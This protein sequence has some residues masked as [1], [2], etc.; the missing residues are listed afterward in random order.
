M[1]RR[2]CL[3]I[4]AIGL[5]LLLTGCA[6]DAPLPP[7]TEPLSL[8]LVHADPAL[9]DG[10]FRRLLDFELPSDLVFVR[11]EG[12][13]P[14]LSPQSPHSGAASLTIPSGCRS[15]AVNLASLLPAN[16]PLSGKWALAGAYL[17]CERDAQVTVEYTPGGIQ[18]SQSVTLTSRPFS[19]PAGQWTGVFVDLTQQPAAAQRPPGTLRLVFS[20]PMPARLWCDD[21]MLVDNTRVLA[22]EDE[23]KSGWS[24]VERGQAITISAAS[25]QLTF[26]TPALSPQGWLLREANDLRARLEQVDSSGAAIAFRT[27]YHDGRQYVD[28][29][30]EPLAGPPQPAQAMQHDS[31]AEVVVPEGMGRLIRNSPGDANNDGYNER[32]GAYEI[33]AKGPRIDVTLS[34]RTPR[35]LRPVLEIAGLPPGDLLVTM[36][37]QLVEGAVRTDEGN[38]LVELPGRIER[39]TTVNVRVK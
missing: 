25:H 38:V 12:K 16:T 18:Q 35:L 13:T 29:D 7:T 36:E 6:D 20:H 24:V 3:P 9:A 31:P 10:R 17:R 21:V 15:I 11:T 28:G 22:G 1:T 5:A 14:Q 23:P 27:I 34:P 33:L 32:R 30:Y 8:Q 2:K 26:Q 4:A 19:L 37:G 39:Q